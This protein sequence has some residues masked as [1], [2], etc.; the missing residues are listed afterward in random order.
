[1]N[2]I[3]INTVKDTG[4][5]GRITAALARITNDHGFHSYIA[6]GRGAL[7]SSSREYRI[8]NKIDFGRHVLYNFTTGRNGFA[9]H[10]VTR[11]FLRWLDDVKPS[12]IHLHN[13]HGFYLHIGLLFDYIKQ[14]NIPVIWTFHD[15]WP[16]TG[17]CA[18]FDYI[19]CDRWVQGCQQC[20]IHRSSYPYSI[21]KDNSQENYRRKKETFTGVKNLTIVTPSHWLADHIRTSFLNEYPV[22]VIPNGIDLQTFKPDKTLLH[23]DSDVKNLLGVANVWDDRKGLPAFLKLAEILDDSYH[24]TLIGLTRRQQKK[25][26]KK[27]PQKITPLLRTNNLE[28][29][30][31]IYNHSS[32][33]INPT[34]EDNFPTVNLEALACG[35]PVITY[36]TGGSPESLTSSC[37]IV[38][39]K[40]NIQTLYDAILNLP[41]SGITREACRKQALCYDQETRFQEYMDLYNAILFPSRNKLP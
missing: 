14:H 35:T 19:Q 36:R 26:Q 29:L 31:A 2:I 28:E 1:M 22:K 12:L 8:G 5:T 27:F 33:F 3:Y 18:Y 10:T 16:F 38:V 11:N 21:F 17:H 40:G 20:S 32:A 25:I 37:G 4:S 7:P 6:Y 34:L 23:Q 39:E 13:I 24:I 15:C 9:S 30:V 41:N